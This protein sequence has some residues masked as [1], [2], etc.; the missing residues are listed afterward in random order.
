MK[1]RIPRLDQAFARLL[2]RRSG[3]G[4][5]TPTTT[6][7]VYADDAVTTGVTR[8]AQAFCST[9]TIAAGSTCDVEISLQSP[10]MPTRRTLGAEDRAGGQG[11]LLQKCNH[12]ISKI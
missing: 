9:S 7:A 4:S 8:A 10:A 11:R 3:E 6:F 1:C 2:S 12:G 5:R